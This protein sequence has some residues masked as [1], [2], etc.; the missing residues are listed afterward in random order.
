MEIQKEVEDLTRTSNVLPLELEALK[1]ELASNKEN[2][3]DEEQGF[4][5]VCSIS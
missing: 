3:N 1:Q 4:N 2:L 5:C